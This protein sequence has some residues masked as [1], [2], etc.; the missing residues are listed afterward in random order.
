M[1]T[2]DRLIH[3]TR[4][5]GHVRTS[6]LSEVDP[7]V[8]AQLK[9]LVC[10]ELDSSDPV[11][12]GGGYWFAG[13]EVN[14]RMH[15]VIRHGGPDS[16]AL[17]RIQVPRAAWVSCEGLP[18]LDV[19]IAG[20]LHQQEGARPLGSGVVSALGDLERCLAWAWLA[21]AE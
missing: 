9:P 4:E 13:H 5:T 18:L 19:E 20:L 14:G 11:H 10:E 16:P 8:L 2:P 7:D 15:G 1:S 3:Q 12:V 17:V 21:Q 6:P